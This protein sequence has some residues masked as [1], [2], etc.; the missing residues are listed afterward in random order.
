M[1]NNVLRK[2]SAFTFRSADSWSGKSQYR[3]LHSQVDGRLSG[4]IVV[5][6][7]RFWDHDLPLPNARHLGHPFHWKN[8]LPW[9]PGPPPNSE[10]SASKLFRNSGMTWSSDTA[11]EVFTRVGPDNSLE[12]LT[13]GS[14]GLVTDR[15]SNVYELL[16]TLL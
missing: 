12:R 15:P 2:E 9:H 5:G 16:V 13:E 4:L 1:A 11:F 10:S 3:R 8:T 7:G 6:F 14:A